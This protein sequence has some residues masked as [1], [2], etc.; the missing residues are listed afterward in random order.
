[1]V[2]LALIRRRQLSADGE[3]ID[4]RQAEVEQDDVGRLG[5][6]RLGTRCRTGHGEPLAAQAVG[7]RLGDRIVVLDDQDVHAETI[8]AAGN[9]CLSGFTD[10]RPRL[11]KP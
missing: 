4:V 6:K 10:S 8:A 5:R 11:T 1:M 9:R 2:F 3:A 7:E